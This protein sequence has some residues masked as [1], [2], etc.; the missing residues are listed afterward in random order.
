MVDD[1]PRDSA[2][3]APA[4]PPP[5]RP[6]AALVVALV[7][8]V[9]AAGAALTLAV[10]P[11]PAEPAVIQPPE[12]PPQP[13]MRMVDLARLPTGGADAEAVDA[14]R[15]QVRARLIPSLIV[16]LD[17]DA[18]AWLRAAIAED[19]AS[20][21]VPQRLGPRDL[22]A[23]VAAP[24]T[25]AALHVRLDD[26]APAG[27]D[28]WQ[29]LLLHLGDEQYAV[30][31]APPDSASL[32]IGADVRVIG[33]YVGRASL[34][35]ADA[36]DGDA[37]QATPLIAARLARID[38]EAIG[39]EP[40]FLAEFRAPRMVLPP[41]LYRDVSDES[42]LADTRP[43]YYLLGQAKYDASTPDVYADAIDANR[44]GSRIH[45]VPSAF[46]GQ[47]VTVAGTVVQVWRDEQAEADRPFEVT[48]VWRA[49]L[50]STDSSEVTE[51]TADGSEVTSIK[52]VSRLFE[53]ALIGPQ[54]PPRRGERVAATG[55]FLKYRAMPITIDRH[56]DAKNQV[57]R[58]SDKVFAL[59]VVAP[60]WWPAPLAPRDASRWTVAA[61][62]TTLVA[63]VIAAGGALIAVRRSDRRAHE[64]RQRPRRKAGKA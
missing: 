38:G 60:A 29:W 24:M 55:R 4:A 48:Q 13:A 59:M 31:L 45:K 49:Q 16:G 25:A 7:F 44:F 51:R 19:I 18:V 50:A 36:G 40:D 62:W 14:A 46:R 64:Q 28:G 17:D 30:A 47:P 58:H 2:P 41:D 8:L 35:V 26:R 42:A 53:I 63:S 23:G 15:A 61:L 5:R 22:V 57:V 52:L 56:R 54:E 10:M 6:R 33:R 11:A 43:Y 1:Q 34:P 12:E 32:D 9:I 37:E 3:S 21:P 20:P 27:D 39:S